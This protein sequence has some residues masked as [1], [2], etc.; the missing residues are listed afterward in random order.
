MRLNLVLTIF[1]VLT[2]LG[3]ASV[4]SGWYMGSASVGYSVVS[5]PAYQT[6]LQSLHPDDL[7]PNENEGEDQWWKKIARLGDQALRIKDNIIHDAAFNFTVPL[8]R[9]HEFER[10]VLD[11]I[12]AI[13]GIK[14]HVVAHGLDLDFVGES[15]NESAQDVVSFLQDEFPDPDTAPGHAEREQMVEAA[16][17]HFGRLFIRKCVELGM[18]EDYIGEEWTKVEA[19]MKKF[20]VLTGDLIE[21]HPLIFEALIVTGALAV[22]PE[23]WIGRQLLGL[24][25]FNPLGP[26]KGSVAA[27]LQRRFWGGAVTKGSWFALLQSTRMAG[28]GWWARLTFKIGTAFAGFAAF[29]AFKS[30][31]GPR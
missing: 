21:Q 3:H 1:T 28:M 16:L 26:G 18:D 13:R 2:S 9:L 20:L 24:F 22:I 5:N 8:E 23:A 31:V 14:D 30:C 11:I 12:V 29:F 27:W 17:A 10:H 25:G 7:K 4:V 19:A 15:L 6:V